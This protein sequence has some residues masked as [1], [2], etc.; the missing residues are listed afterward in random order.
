MN[1]TRIIFTILFWIVL[2]ILFELLSDAVLGDLSLEMQIFA[3]FF[4]LAAGT[5]VI[6]LLWFWLVLR[7]R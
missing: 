1:R 2:S 6:N 5:L 7:K 3:W 4:F